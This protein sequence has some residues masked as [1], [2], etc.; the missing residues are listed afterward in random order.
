[1][2]KVVLARLIGRKSG[3]AAA[4][5]TAMVMLAGFASAQDGKSVEE[6]EKA[7]AQQRTALEEA[8]ANR[9]QIAAK[10]A[11][12]QAELGESDERRTELEEQLKTLCEEQETLNDVSF[13]SCIT[14]ENN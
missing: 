10:V 2:M 12:I 5:I 14:D 11:E 6:L 8:I 13:Q 7:I 9:E 1:M 3:I 4:L